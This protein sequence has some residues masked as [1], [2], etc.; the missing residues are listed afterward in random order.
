[1]RP[2]LVVC[3]ASV[4]GGCLSNTHRVPKGELM[5]LAQ[6][7]PAE[8]GRRVRVI[9]GF[10]G[11]EGP[12]EAPAVH[13]G[14]AVVVTPGPSYGGGPARRTPT[15]AKAQSMDS[16]GWIVVAAIAALGLT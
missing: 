16:K 11:D 2:L 9:Q 12:P 8:H 1:M 6:V 14:V 5:M 3:L 15:P 7:P 4:L 10:A 13:V